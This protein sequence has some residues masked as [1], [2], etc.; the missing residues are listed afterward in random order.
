MGPEQ[1]QN[2]IHTSTTISGTKPY[3]VVVDVYALM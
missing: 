1:L 3:D 2:H